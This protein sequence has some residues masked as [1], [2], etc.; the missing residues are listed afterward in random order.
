MGSSLSST[1]K[2]QSIPNEPKAFVE[3]EVGQHQVRPHPWVDK[4]HRSQTS[5][6]WAQLTFFFLFGMTLFHRLS[7]GL[8]LGVDSVPQ[9]NHCL[10]SQNSVVWT[11]KFMSSI[12]CPTGTPSNQFCNKWPGSG[13]CLVSGLSGSSL[14]EMMTRMRHSDLDY[15]F[16]FSDWRNSMPQKFTLYFHQP[17]W[18]LVWSCV[19]RIPTKFENQSITDAK[20]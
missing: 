20:Y 5:R 8:S 13:R 3:K 12:S 16:L 7:Y 18:I 14:E 2:T 6:C 19:K 4:P 11:W 9:Q 1:S 10:G 15:F 17:P